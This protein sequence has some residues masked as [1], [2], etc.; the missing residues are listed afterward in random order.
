MII[1]QLHDQ[2]VVLVNQLCFM[3]KLAAKLTEKMLQFLWKFSYWSVSG[4][5]LEVEVCKA[6]RENI[7]FESLATDTQVYGQE[8]EV[9]CTTVAFYHNDKAWISV[10]RKLN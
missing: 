9:L 2:R 8:L 10:L 7:I 1:E 4:W 3:P 5:S 6:K